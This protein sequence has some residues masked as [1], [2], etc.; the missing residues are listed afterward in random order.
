[1]ATKQLFIN[2]IERALK[3]GFSTTDYK[4]DKLN[5]ALVIVP[6]TA[7]FAIEPM[8]EAYIV[9]GAVT[10]YY[11]VSTIRRKLT[12]FTPSR[13]WNY[14]IGLIS[15]TIYLQRVI[16]PNRGVTQRF[17]NVKL[18]VWDKMQQYISVYAPTLTLSPELI[19]KTE[20]VICPDLQWTQPTLFE[21][22]NDLLKTV[23]AVVSMPNYTTVSYLDLAER[24]S[25]VD[26]A[27][28]NNMEVYQSIDEYASKLEI[29][30]KNAV[31]PETNIQT[32]ESLVLKTT[33]GEL[34]TVDNAELIL[35]KNIYSIDKIEVELFDTN[36][37]LEDITSHIVEKKIYNSYRA[38]NTLD[39][40]TES[41][42]KRNAI[43]YEE[44]SNIIGGFGFNE[45]G[46]LG[47][48]TRIAINNIIT[49]EAG[50]SPIDLN[51]DSIFIMAFRVWYTSSEDVKFRVESDKTNAS[52]MINNQDTSHVDLQ[53]LARNNQ[54][55]ANRIG[56]PMATIYGKV[57]TRAELP[58]LSD[59]MDDYVITSIIVRHNVD[60]YEFT[61]DLTENY[62]MENMFTAIKN[63]KR[64]Q[65]FESSQQAFLSEHIT[66]YDILVT[67]N[68]DSN[69]SDF[70]EFLIQFAKANYRVRAVIA[71]ILFNNS[72]VE[73]IIL[74]HSAHWLGT[75][76][77]RLNVKMDDN[78]SAGIRLEKETVFL[79]ASRYSAQHTP[80]VDSNGEFEAIELLLYKDFEN[81]NMTASTAVLRA[82]ALDRARQF[83]LIT[84]GLS[85]Y[86]EDIVFDTNLLYRY[87]DNREITSETLQFYFKPDNHIIIG[88]AFYRH[89]PLVYMGD[90]DIPL[91][92]Y[93]SST[94]TYVDGDQEAKGTN[95]SGVVRSDNSIK[96][97]LTFAQW[98]ALSIMS[99][100]VAD[101]SGNMYLA[102]NNNMRSIYLTTT[103]N[104]N[105]VTY[106]L[107]GL[108]IGSTIS[109]IY[110][111]GDDYQ[112]LD[113]EFDSV[114]SEDYTAGVHYSLEDLGIESV[115]SEFHE[116]GTDYFLNDLVISSVL[117]KDYESLP[118][119][120]LAGLEIGSVLSK[121]Y[122]GIV[123][124][125]YE[126]SGVEFGSVVSEDYT[127][128]VSTGYTLSD[129]VIGSSIGNNYTYVGWYS[130]GA[131][132]VG[133]SVCTLSTHIGNVK[134]DAT[135]S[136]CTWFEDGGMYISSTDETYNNTLTCEQ[137][138]DK[139]ECAF[140][141]RQWYCQYY[142]TAPTYTYTN[143]KT[144]GVI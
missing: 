97:S 127:Y 39:L 26:T 93:V 78:Y 25:A 38:S 11:Y 19:E 137:A 1:M 69:Y 29:D 99:W 47:I 134:C 70:E 105:V 138:P 24:G 68:Y 34:M 104:Y 140:L 87:K 81:P 129:L 17:R 64:Y 56:N 118:D 4:N 113:L 122:E 40:I 88:D 44:G 20:N 100:C 144:C 143:C 33:Q 84:D 120:Q 101:A 15:P 125:A 37:I 57:A 126:L 131:Q 123:P 86:A 35:A 112:L 6:Q 23:N 98:E 74:N 82:E 121:D 92:V 107:S 28:L 8:D 124:D 130:A 12:S 36:A 133:A 79:I 10:R 135:E 18:S 75:N 115:L 76:A 89:N 59:T 54:D 62:I 132:P 3:P 106:E 83:P 5:T 109:S 55:I 51:A 72:S 7:E 46:I 77:V 91:Y 141:A 110:V 41:D 61:C 108:V 71:N 48:N 13:M 85:I 14:E 119:Y 67:T 63:K 2:G 65:Q 50:L 9:D 128:S 42:Y 116:A 73:N 117:S 94:E 49:V 52:V 136:G 30:A 21:V 32:Y 45:N 96:S 43:W 95:V 90:V 80:Y 58:E 53:A 66:E 60:D 139:V 31:Y 114:L 22:F 27:V 16:L 103:Y 102:V 111:H 142:Q